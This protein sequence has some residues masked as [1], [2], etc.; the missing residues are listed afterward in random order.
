MGDSIVIFVNIVHM[1]I[2]IVGRGLNLSWL[3]WQAWTSARQ[4]IS[5]DCRI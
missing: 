5:K 4:L 3:C 1:I 2:R